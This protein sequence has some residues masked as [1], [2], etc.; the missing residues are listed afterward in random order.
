MRHLSRRK[1]PLHRRANTVVPAPYVAA[2]TQEFDGNDG[3]WSTFAI[4]VGTPGQSF[5][6]LPS[7]SGSETWLP[8]PDGCTS[9]DP[10]N[11]ATSRGAD[12]F[13]GKASSGFETNQSSTWN[14]IGLYNL[15]LEDNL[16]YSGNGEY[17]FDTVAL[18]SPSDS[19]KLSQNHTV[20][21][22][23]A[24]KDYFLGI[25]GLGNRPLSFSSSSA[26]AQSFL[27][28]A[29]KETIPSLSYAYTAGAVYQNKQQPGQLIL[30]G[31]DS[32]RFTAND[33]S[34]SFS[35]QDSRALSVGVQSIIGDNTLLGTASFTQDGGFLAVIDSTVPYLYLPNSTCD[36][37]A[38]ALGLTFDGTT[39]LYRVN[40]TIHSKLKSSNPTFTF[41]I[42]NTAFDNGNSTNIQLPYAAF[43]LAATWP[44]YQTSTNYFPIRRSQNDS[45][46]TI[47]RAFL[48]EAYLIVDYERQ[49][50]SISQAV[51][52]DPM[53]SASVAPIQP[54]SLSTD[55]GSS[56]SSSKLSGGAIAGIVIGAIAGVVL[57]AL[58]AWLLFHRRRKQKA[59]TAELDDTQVSQMDGYTKVAADDAGGPAEMEGGRHVAEMDTPQGTKMPGTPMSPAEVDGET[60]MTVGRHEMET[61]P[62]RYEMEGSSPLPSPMP[63]PPDHAQ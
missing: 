9:S 60:Y 34:F 59:K 36:S 27:Q 17:G 2:P 48:Q 35:G 50:F 47:G 23:I 31:Y 20:V 19:A 58:G 54:T 21:A 29:N 25:F 5:R 63:K 51:F 18:G 61:P 7:T 38:D 1:M 22:G 46:Y 32:S 10:D 49:N 28:L 4:S 43:D 16:N 55:N 30:G 62:I 13:N 39:Q 15:G 6:I 40:D 52:K 14:Q 8:V 44:I 3:Q 24:A 41:K 42:G 53:P 56:A 45:Q 37:M 11:C 12:P 26:N 33:Q 57:L